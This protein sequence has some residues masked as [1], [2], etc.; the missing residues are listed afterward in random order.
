[1]GVSNE[2]NML[3]NGIK[4]AEYAAEV[5]REGAK[6]FKSWRQ[7]D[8]GIRVFCPLVDSAFFDDS[9]GISAGNK[10]LT[11][12]NLAMADYNSLIKKGLNLPLYK[13]DSSLSINQ[14]IPYES[15]ALLKIRLNHGVSTGQKDGRKYRQI[16]ENMLLLAIDSQLF[17]EFT[18]GKTIVYE[19]EIKE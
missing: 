6:L 5:E 16:A 18:P 12:L 15:I 3:Y 1:V 8:A 17:V 10:N 7:W 2:K 19:K 14:T 9:G 13:A 4:N 11:E